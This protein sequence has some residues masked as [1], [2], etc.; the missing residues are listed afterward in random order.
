[1]ADMMRVFCPNLRGQVADA[2]GV[3]LHF[4]SDGVARFARDHWGAVVKWCSGRHDANI[5]QPGEL[6]PL[7]E[8][9]AALRDAETDNTALRARLAELSGRVEDAESAL[10]DARDE[11]SSL[12]RELAEARKARKARKVDEKDT[13]PAA[14]KPAAKKSAAGKKTGTK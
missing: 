7:A 14:R 5:V 10:G 13:K 4:G 2:L 9:Q 12:E 8:V 3:P 1:M 11:V 6:P